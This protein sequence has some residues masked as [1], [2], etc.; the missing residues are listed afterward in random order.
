MVVCGHNKKYYKG[1]LKMSNKNLTTTTTNT[2]T[3]TTNSNLYIGAKTHTFYTNPNPT[4][5]QLVDIISLIEEICYKYNCESLYTP[6]VDLIP[7]KE[8][9]NNRHD[10]T[11]MDY[12]I[13]LCQ[14][15]DTIAHFNNINYEYS[16]SDLLE[17]ISSSE[18]IIPMGA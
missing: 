12:Q 2:Y 18:E 3:I 9:I 13:L 7:F 14:I 16:F 15:Q 11:K 6:G 5:K 10:I 17:N 1:D 4:N 8:R